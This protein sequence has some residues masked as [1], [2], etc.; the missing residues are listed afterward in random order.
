L[1]ALC[2]L[3]FVTACSGKA[4]PDSPSFG[5]AAA[6]IATFRDVPGITPEEIAAIDALKENRSFF[7]FGVEPH[8]TEAIID[9]K[10]GE[11]TGFSA[12]L[13]EWL[14][15]F[16]EF[17]FVP[18]VYA[19]ASI[20]EG[21]RNFDVDFTAS[22]SPTEE[23]SRTYFMTDSIAHRS[24]KC[25]RIAGSPPP[26]E[27]ERERPVHYL[28][29]ERAA[30]NESVLAALVPGTYETTFIATNEDA[31]E[32]LK[33]EMADAYVSPSHVEGVFDSFGDVVTSDFFPLIFLSIPLSTQNP[34]LKPII[35]CVQKMMDSNR[36]PHI[37]EL[38]DKGQII[39]QKHKLWLALTDAERS[40]I[41]SRSVIPVVANADNYPVCFYNTREGEWQGIFFDLL[42]EISMFTGLAFEIANA[43]DASWP[44]VY[45][46]ARTG[47]ASI[48]GSLV[49]TPEREAYFIWPETSMQPDHYA[50]ISKSEYPDITV[51][52][53][54][55]A[56]VALTKDTSYT[57]TFKRWFPDHANAVEY[58]TIDAALAALD[59]GEMDLVMATQR[60]LLLLTHYQELPGYKANLVFDEPIETKFGFYKD[61]VL[62]CSIVDKA[63]KIIDTRGISDQWMRRTYD[64]RVKVAQARFPFLVGASVMSLIIVAMMVIMFLRSLGARKRLTQLVEEE[65]ATLT[66][67]LDGTPDHLF[68]KDLD[69]RYTR[70]NKVMADF[71]QIHQAD[72]IGKTDVEALGIPAEIAADLSIIEKKVF[73]EGQAHTNEETVPLPD[74]RMLLF[75]IVRAPLILDGKVTGLVAMARDITRRKA[76][77]DEA[78]RASAEAMRAFAEAESASEAKSRFIANMSHEMRTPMNVIVGLT[79][80]M[81]E[82]DAVPDAAKETLKK[83]STAGNTLTGLINDVL[84]I[85]KIESG[86]QDLNPVQYEMASFLNDI[87]TLNMVRIGEKPIT[88]KLD[89]NEKMPHIL[90]GDDL[91]VKQILNNLLSNAFKYTKEGTVT[92]SVTAETITELSETAASADPAAS[93]PHLWVSFSISDTGIGI[94]KEDIAKLFSDYNQVDTKANREIE[95]TGLGLS[96][97]KKFVEMMGGEI[98]VESEYGKGTTFRLHIQQGFVSDAPIGKETADNLRSFRYTDKKKQ[99]QG[100]FTRKNLSYAKVL[101]VDDFPMNLDVA[102]GM[103]RKYKMQVDTATSGREAVDRIAAGD[104]AYDAVFMDHMMPG[105][106]G[107]E[108]TKLIRASGT[109]YAAKLPI[110]ALTANAVA[111]N[112]QMFLENGFS[113]FL[114]KPFSAMALDAVVQKW[115]R[116]KSK[117]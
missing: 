45:N 11:I 47:E 83:I 59:R 117:E 21:L 7:V 23:R 69:R 52:G 39:Y 26:R 66:A 9:E 100:K 112:E 70:C 58:E 110:I 36:L 108:A 84:D 3:L 68:C 101:V 41:A 6:P 28:M 74:G 22:L 80:L 42:D 12:L 71:H 34:D 73:E 53:L 115:V 111:G 56:R 92:L 62:L 48:I 35:S 82:E 51:N 72:I 2:S 43:H 29:M 61:E 54:L 30:V 17:P 95:G 85:S 113:A 37:S 89:I 105:M 65:T 64:Y 55:H 13:C 33:K 67:I 103:L 57:A 107:M 97:T 24:V 46:K 116:Q 79:D 76:A 96:I 10:T 99:S 98:T 14:S 90:F 60:R 31:Y 40:H 44:L 102:A 63:L 18:K 20:V 86:K 114:P 91:R 50:L 87:V 27:I 1:I 75:E 4:S 109:E 81:L 25:Y 93:T 19:F 38:Y 5:R 104:P 8:T 16:F 94:R 78:K 77:E 88:F 106:D 49:R 15:E 32:L